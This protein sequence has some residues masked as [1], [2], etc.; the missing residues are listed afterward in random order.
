MRKP[1]WYTITIVNDKPIGGGGGARK[2]T[3]DEVIA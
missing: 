3:M 1:I 2:T